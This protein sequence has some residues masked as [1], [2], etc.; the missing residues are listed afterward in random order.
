MRSAGDRRPPSA[1]VLELHVFCVPAEL[2]NCKLNTV[3]THA[4]SKFISAGFVRVLPDLSLKALRPQI[5]DLFGADTADERFVFLKCVGRSF[6]VVRAK[7]ELELKVKSFAPPYAPQPEL[8]L[9][10]GVG[11]SGWRELINSFTPNGQQFPKEHS[12]S[13]MPRPRPRGTTPDEN[14]SSGEFKASSCSCRAHVTKSPDVRS[15]YETHQRPRSTNRE[16]KAAARERK[17]DGF[18][19]KVHRAGSP[20]KTGSYVSLHGPPSANPEESEDSREFEASGVSQQVHST[21]S[22]DFNSTW[23]Q[24]E[25]HTKP[26]IN[27]RQANKKP[28]RNQQQEHRAQQR[29]K[30]NAP[31]GDVQVDISSVSKE[32][33]IQSNSMRDSGVPE[34][35]DERDAEY[36]ENQRMKSQRLNQGPESR[37]AG[38]RTCQMQADDKGTHCESVTKRYPLP[39]LPP[40]LALTTQRPHLQLL[41]T[42][43]EQLIAQINSTK[44]ERKYLEKTREE[45]VKKAKGL[46][47]QNRLRRNQVRDNWKKKYFE[48]KKVTTPL[49]E[50]SSKLRQE[51][52]TYYLKLLQQLEARDTR[53]RPRKLTNTSSSKNELI[54]Q[55]T[56]FKHEIDQLYRRVENAKMKL[57]T[58]MKLRK[59][60]SRDLRAL[61]AELAQKK[62]QSSLTHLHGGPVPHSTNI[63]AI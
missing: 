31:M 50:I 8:Y 45:L 2:W 60:T 63:L 39:P 25:S 33:R 51:L 16:E 21:R 26:I 53:K 10:P 24:K 23:E 29:K 20:D 48:S 18:P 38:Q 11:H 5:G 37:N 52:G 1:G 19:G 6:A 34:S 47:S 9:L 22:P 62:T 44:Q 36:L 15:T 35:L 27:T 58:E 55:I 46:L 57:I 17:T 41:P 14:E 61:R 59:Q 54:I 4:I 28:L 40:L 32:S 7:Q 43:K 56:T 30:E 12:E 49:E 3:S 13:C 42:D